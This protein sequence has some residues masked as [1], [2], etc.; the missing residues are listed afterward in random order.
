MQ[1]LIKKFFNYMISCHHSATNRYSNK[2]NNKK[3]NQTFSLPNIKSRCFCNIKKIIEYIR[4]FLCTELYS[5]WNANSLSL[6]QDM[7][8]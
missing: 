2:A 1:I 8:Y 4:L 6:C 3:V 5:N 7:L